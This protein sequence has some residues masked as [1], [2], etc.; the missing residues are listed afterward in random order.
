MVRPVGL[1]AALIVVGAVG[2]YYSGI[3]NSHFRPNNLDV[4]VQQAG[5]TVQSVVP[6]DALIVVVDDYGATSPLLLYYAHRK[7][8]SFDV[9][10]VQPQVIDGLRRMNARFFV[11][12]VWSRVEHD[13]P[14]AAAYLHLYRRVPL[15]DEPPGMAIFDL[16][17]R[18]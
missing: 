13:R 11:S 8:W 2:F 7:G 14:D 5:S 9:E 18:D 6:A 10:N 12:T 16:T 3:I 17:A 4:R 15:H 1:A